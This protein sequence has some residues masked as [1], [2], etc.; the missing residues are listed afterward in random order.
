M[1]A[2]APS[3]DVPLVLVGRIAQSRI[4]LAADGAAQQIGLQVGMPATKAQAMVPNLMIRATL[5]P[6][7]ME[8]R[9][10]ADRVSRLEAGAK[11]AE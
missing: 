7:L 8:W 11:M 6:W 1:G 5:I 2:A 10:A 9:V 4:V 3:A